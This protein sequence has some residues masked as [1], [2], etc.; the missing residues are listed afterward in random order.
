M[1]VMERLVFPYLQQNYEELREAY[2]EAD[3][4]VANNSTYVASVTAEKLGLKWLS[5]FL[6]PVG[7]FSRFDPPVLPGMPLQTRVGPRA[8]WAHALTFELAKRRSR[9]FVEPIQLLR[10]RIGL[11]R[12]KRHP[13][14]ESHSP[15]GNMAWFSRLLGSWRPDW[16]RRTEVTGFLTYDGTPD[17]SP[18]DA[19]DS[20]LRDG[21]PPL[22]FTL[23]S[24]VH[25]HPGRFFEE[26]AAIA[27]TLRM[28]AVLVGIPE[29]GDAGRAADRNI[30]CSH[31]VSYS[32]LFPKASI[33]VHPG[34]IGTIATALRA[35]RPMIIVPFAHDQP[36]NAHRTARLGVARV[37]PRDR[38]RHDIVAPILKEML[39]DPKMPLRSAH[40]SR[41]L[42]AE[43]GIANACRFIERFLPPQ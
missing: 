23:G 5:V 3:L 43:N 18:D 33:I 14:F 11:Q 24:S 8:R 28:R 22:V 19:L 29:L 38:Y 15:F 6:Q 36:D 21:D 34:G 4:I 41:K 2:R 26:S 37:I 25:M 30:Y 7:F 27:N 39:E 42:T 1:A 16:P 20:F 9:E 13:I 32:Y 35:A 12:T 10:E 40:L 31:Y 17:A